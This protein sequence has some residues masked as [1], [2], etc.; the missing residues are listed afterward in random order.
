[1]SREHGKWGAHLFY[2]GSLVSSVC[3][4][5]PASEQVG[6]ATGGGRGQEGLKVGWGRASLKAAY[7]RKYNKQ[8]MGQKS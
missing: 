8:V 4:L 3:H 7:R 2:T 5:T 6:S 1:M